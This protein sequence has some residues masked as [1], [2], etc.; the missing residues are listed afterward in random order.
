VLVASISDFCE[1]RGAAHDGH[2]LV[3]FGAEKDGDVDL[4]GAL[5][6]AG[7]VR[8]QVT[9]S[10]VVLSG[11]RQHPARRLVHIGRVLQALRDGGEHLRLV[12][13][14]VAVAAGLEAR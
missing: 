14:P 1:V 11:V 5:D 12:L 8:E 6:A 4:G 7:D 10:A 9:L 2:A 3:L 13:L